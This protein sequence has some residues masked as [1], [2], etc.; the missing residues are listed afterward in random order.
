[1]ESR[2]KKLK[3]TL[4]D[5]PLRAKPSNLF[6][7][8]GRLNTEAI[9]VEYMLDGYNVAIIPDF[10]DKF[11]PEYKPTIDAVWYCT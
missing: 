1:M 11:I 6:L 3:P 5:Q 8:D 10:M 2:I 4:R 7:D 9:P